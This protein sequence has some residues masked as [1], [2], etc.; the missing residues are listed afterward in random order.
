[1]GPTFQ[2]MFTGNLL[3]AKF[4][5]DVPW[6]HYFRVT[7]FN[8]H[9]SG[10]YTLKPAAWWLATVAA[11]IEMLVPLLTWSNDPCK[12]TYPHTA[13]VL[14]LLPHTAPVLRLLLAI[15]IA[16]LFFYLFFP[17]TVPVYL[18]IF[19][20]MG[21]HAFIIATLI[22]DVFAWNFTDACW[23]VIL[24]GILS[25]GVDWTDYGNMHPLLTLWFIVHGCY[26]IYGHIYVDEVP[27]VVAH[28]HAA[29]H[30]VAHVKARR[31]VEL[32][33]HQCQPR[34]QGCKAR[35]HNGAARCPYARARGRTQT[36]ARQALCMREPCQNRRQQKQKQHEH[37]A[38]S[39]QRIECGHE[40]VRR[41][42]HLR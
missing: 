5:S 9:E 11:S 28:R 10:D 17:S 32:R 15:P 29:L 1:M 25:T 42:R 27:Y 6:A 14:R 13:P 7:F 35:Q 33:R 16:I 40:G 3:T 34:G 38:A 22:I 20:F 31:V 23:Y 8:G 26:V 37:A 41:H 19:T 4:M 36:C 21:M 12:Q 24:Y 2:Y 30:T 39:E 18:S